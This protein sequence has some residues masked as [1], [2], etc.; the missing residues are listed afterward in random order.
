[1][2]FLII[3]LLIILYSFFDF[4]KAFSFYLCYKLV[5]VTN[6]TVIS[7]PGLPLLTLEMAMTL[8]FIIVFIFTGKKYQNAH[9]K[10]PFA[11]PLILYS[12]SLL[13]SSVLSIAGLGSEFSNI[14]KQ[15]AENVLLVWMTWQVFETKDDFK[16][17]FVGITIVILLSCLYGFVEYL[18]K[19]NPLTK[20][21]ATLNKDPDK[22]I[23]YI[24]STDSRGYRINSFFEHAIGAGMIWALYSVFVFILIQNKRVKIKK[25]IIPI[26]AA[27]LCLPCIFL[28]KM[29]SPILFLGIAMLAIVNLNSKRF[30][31]IAIGFLLGAVVI[32][33]FVSDDI[34]NV[35]LGIFDKESAAEIG[36]SSID[37]RIDQFAAAFEL[38]RLSPLFGLGP[39]FSDV[40]NN[41]T[42]NR[43]LGGES[44]WLGVITQLGLFGVVVYIIQLYYFVVKIPMYFNR[45][46]LFFISLAYWVTCSITSVPGFSMMLYYLCI[47]YF[48]KTSN[49][50]KKAVNYGKVYGIYISRGIIHYNVIKHL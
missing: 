19:D 24:Y 48:I 33:P 42:V 31:N 25:Y 20:Y 5:L 23:D 6:I 28:T 18:I 7:K 36:G 32:L 15:L 26:I 1:M 14:I 8:I 13:I 29:R 37:M 22:L 41:E 49:R 3:G 38:L 16:F 39:S 45:K 50:Y 40:L 9:S 35:V 44:V 12:I 11:V 21:E 17:L 27:I 4:K 30:R 47:F 2:I 10:F 34:I 46:E 43:L